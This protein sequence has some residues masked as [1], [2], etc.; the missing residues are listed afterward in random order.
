MR[1]LGAGLTG[2]GPGPDGGRDGYFEGKAPYP[3]NVDHWEGTWYIQSKFHAAHLST[4]PQKWLLNQIQLEINSF[5]SPTSRRFIPDIWII[6]TNIEPSGVA[7][8]G[9][10][11]AAREMVAKFSPALAK[12]FQIWGGRKILDFL[13]SFPNIADYYGA[14]LTPGNI[15]KKL[16]DELSDNK[17]DLSEIFRYLTVTQM[18]EQQYTKLEQAG[19]TVDNR[20]GIQRLFTDLPFAGNKIGGFA[21]ANLAKT[22][23]QVHRLPLLGVADPS[24]ESWSNAPSRARA[25]FVK[26]GP[27]QGK[28][29]LTQYIA[30]I[31][32]AALI[33][34]ATEIAITPTQAS[35]AEE[36][37]S[38]SRT[39]GLWPETPRIPV[40]IELKEF[41]FWFGQRSPSQSQR[42][43]TF[44]AERLTREIGM[45]VL[46][47][48][49]KRAFAHSRWLFIF[50]GLDE[51]P[52]DV[53]DA[54]ANE[55]VH[56]VDDS[57]ISCN[58]DAMIV[59]TSRPQGYSGQFTSLGGAT[60]ELSSLSPD[61]ALKCATPVLRIDRSESDSRAFI[62]ILRE[63]LKSPAIAEIMTTPLQ[64]HIMAVIVR[65]GGRPPER[66]WKLFNT[67]YEIIKKREANR[68]LPDKN[69]ATLL[70]EGD[71]LLKALHNRLGFELHARAETSKG[72]TTA[73]PRDGLK[74]I[75]TETVAKLQDKAVRPTVATLMKATTERL[76][77][78]NTPESGEY[79]RFDIRPLQEFFA[80]EYLYR[81]GAAEYFHTRIRTIASDAHWREVMH[82]LISALVENGRS[83]DLAIA[84]S[85]LEEIDSG[86][87]SE[88][89]IFN[90]RLAK[91]ARITSRLLVEGVLEED[92]QVRSRF[93]NSM[94]P[95]AGQSYPKELIGR[96]L[97]RHSLAWLK[98]ALIIAL[99]EQALTETMGAAACLATILPDRDKR[100]LDIEKFVQDAG[101]TYVA[102]FL[103]AV[104][105]E[106]PFE[107]KKFP[108]WV[109]RIACR[110]LLSPNWVDFPENSLRAAAFIAASDRG[111][112]TEELGA[113]N[114][115]KLIDIY[116]SA[117][118]S[119]GNKRSSRSMPVVDRRYGFMDT[120]I[121]PMNPDLEFE[122]W[123][124]EIWEELTE[125]KGVFSAIGQT[126][127]M[128]KLRTKESQEHF[129]ESLGG[130]FSNSKL[131]PSP[132][133]GFLNS[134]IKD[135]DEKES[136][137]SE[138][139]FE[140]YYP[141]RERYIISFG[142][143][144]KI[145]LNGVFMNQQEM[146][147]VILDDNNFKKEIDEFIIDKSKL[148]LIQNEA[149]RMGADDISY[150]WSVLL[151]HEN[152]FVDSVRKSLLSAAKSSVKR[153]PYKNIVRTFPVK[154]PEESALLPHLV[155]A[156][157]DALER[158]E[159]GLPQVKQN[160]R[161]NL[162][163]WS[164]EFV[165]RPGV[166]K[167]IWS[168]TDETPQVRLAAFI[169]HALHSQ[170]EP[171]DNLQPFLSLYDDSCAEW[172]LPGIAYA[173][174][175]RILENETEAL[176]M[177][178]TCLEKSTNNFFGRAALEPVF[179][180]WR[181]AS[182]SPV[183][184]SKELTAWN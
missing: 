34:G 9:C 6:A 151:K 65:D 44:L 94:M 125:G 56:F 167:K 112:L 144:E 153:H 118:R 16:H 24:W 121:E 59:C 180:A 2:F 91:G 50:D 159:T 11:D 14:F 1:V 168:K 136:V 92:K 55:V 49:L 22:I 96:K 31:Q 5:K 83:N 77:L 33:L 66:R 63:A 39:Q 161:A 15:L 99:R 133:Q 164:A 61:L 128:L 48:T 47:G 175:D 172:A 115:S 43:I 120:H 73:I 143:S 69:L 135:L 102:F 122:Q 23:A 145:D 113:K 150:S 26:G 139:I 114:S 146:L 4:D 103:F 182:G 18:M 17:A 62:D 90:R 25:W 20:P 37:R 32:R 95:I 130:R 162:A 141:G 75:V 78:V 110:F 85:I 40:T 134:K 41:A 13:S 29:T 127:K 173:L 154:L 149:I 35:V 155:G 116:C 67:F 104:Y 3:S 42:T 36:I 98:D 152:I 107:R 163:E 179:K 7:E 93:L 156:M 70:R 87:S 72:A 174:F 148:E 129:L 111:V 100:S 147:F 101:L 28:S 81:D 79:V 142:H 30:Q 140:H 108:R 117:L 64:A 54:V 181:E 119:D 131:L 169:L 27:G 38:I 160:T 126:F 10:F 52:G 137:T 171:F 12:K 89:R 58:S 166:L 45:P 88:T 19:S 51:V 53:K 132:I 183:T 76:V 60:I 178:S 157:I 21:A 57:L 74:K 86:T 177:F 123:S 106:T 97:Q 176:T 80:A 84:T 109:V 105:D 158:G 138:D 68:N 184:S 82:F 71:K 124:P 165:V 8:T 46:A 170:S